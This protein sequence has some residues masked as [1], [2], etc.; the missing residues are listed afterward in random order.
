MDFLKDWMEQREEM[1][2][3]DREI[4]AL[5]QH[6]VER[7]MDTKTECKRE[8]ANDDDS[9]DDEDDNTEID[10]GNMESS[11]HSALTMQTS[12]AVLDI[13]N[14]NSVTHPIP[15]T[16]SSYSTMHRSDPTPL[17]HYAPASN[18]FY[19]STLAFNEI[20]TD[21]AF[22][23]SMMFTFDRSSDMY[24]NDVS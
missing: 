21:T 13:Q 1:V 24:A 17:S 16:A 9:H 4:E 3:P 20:M 8:E 5:S 7:D 19:F 10:D 11:E 15:F 18:D 14:M 22:D 6:K 2:T 12:T 23:D